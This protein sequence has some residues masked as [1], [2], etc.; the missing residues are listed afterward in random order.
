MTTMQFQPTDEIANSCL[1]GQVTTTYERLVQVFGLPHNSNL[2]S[3]R[4]RAHWAFKFADGTVATIYDWK[5]GLEPWNNVHWNI[6][7]HSIRAEALVKA[8]LGF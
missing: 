6:G 3:S 1:Q 7:G 5:T 8:A 2:E 4:T